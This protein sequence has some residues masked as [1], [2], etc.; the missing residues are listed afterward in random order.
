MTV[1]KKLLL[2]LFQYCV[3]WKDYSPEEDTWEPKESFE[4]GSEHFIE[5][6]WS[7]EIK[8]LNGRDPNQTFQFRHGEELVA[9][10][11]LVRKRGDEESSDEGNEGASEAAGPSNHRTR[12]QSPNL[13]S[14][15]SAR[16]RTTRRDQRPP[17]SD[18]EED[19][20]EEPLSR[21]NHHRPTTST[22]RNKHRSSAS[23]EEEVEALIRPRSPPPTSISAPVRSTSSSKKKRRKPGPGRDSQLIPED[24]EGEPVATAPIPS[25]HKTKTSKKPK[26]RKPSPESDDEPM[27]SISHSRKRRAA[28]DE[29]A[30]SK[31]PTA[32]RRKLKAPPRPPTDD[33]SS[34]D[35]QIVSAP[36]PRRTKPRKSSPE[37]EIVEQAPAPSP[38]PYQPPHHLFGTPTMLT[39]TNDWSY[40]QQGIS[41]PSGDWSFSLDP[42]PIE[43]ELTHNYPSQ[44]STPNFDSF[45]PRSQYT[46]A[47]TISSGTSTPSAPQ[48]QRPPASTNAGYSGQTN[49]GPSSEPNVGPSNQPHAGSAGHSQ[50]STSAAPPE[51]PIPFHRQRAANPR[52]RLMDDFASTQARGIAAKAKF[53]S[54]TMLTP[55]KP[56]SSTTPPIAS[57]APSISS[58][59]PPMP[60]KP[61]ATRPVSFATR[62]NMSATPPIATTP[63]PALMSPRPTGVTST[64]T[65]AT[66]VK[67]RAPL[68]KRQPKGALLV[69]D[70]EKQV[71]RPNRS[72]SAFGFGSPTLLE[73][74]PGM[75]EQ[76]QSP[77]MEQQQRPAMAQQQPQSAMEVERTNGVG[78]E[79]SSVT[80]GGEAVL[81]EQANAPKEEDGAT[82]GTDTAM[83]VKDDAADGGWQQ[84][85][86]NGELDAH[87]LFGESTADLFGDNET[88]LFGD[89]IPGLRPDSPPPSGEDLLRLAT[90]KPVA[91]ETLEDYEEPEQESPAV[92]PKPAESTAYGFPTAGPNVT[93]WRGSTIFGP[94]YNPVEP[95]STT[96]PN[97]TSEQSKFALKL[98]PDRWVPLV[99]VGSVPVP[100]APSLSFVVGNYNPGGLVPGKFYGTNVMHSL[101][102]SVRSTGPAARALCSPTASIDQRA[103]FEALKER[104]RAGELFIVTAGVQVLAFC[105]SRN[106]GA[107]ARLNLP[108]ALQGQPD[109][110]LM[111]RVVIENFA[112]YAEVAEKATTM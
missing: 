68:P 112:A 59:T 62:P 11:P 2:L 73:Q 10:G 51:K 31:R 66:L 75:G 81:D 14:S 71:L 90:G 111:S 43:P 78:N 87:D 23:D 61:T 8:G 96:P 108:P 29:K 38:Q 91:E 1:E 104:L 83:D 93:T 77:V 39:D 107:V 103:D 9:V 89:G 50:P 74:Q 65:G 19:S 18:D 84:G 88:D 57:A 28:D 21:S 99:L 37:P 17:P 16:T 13:P 85:D 79:S 58:T 100:D 63:N 35:I 47:L 20:D 5:E 76:R 105:H 33:G 6:F 7:R 55:A 15:S 49:A 36:I 22:S 97:D 69:Y 106:E 56:A 32:K 46:P 64:K 98:S 80:N 26:H 34:S 42:E 60:V 12:D 44:S 102:D 30:L 45:L 48:S 27:P 72:P 24:D 52:V 109:E 82:S 54:A 95:A 86:T 110:V 53:M 40:G 94:L 3:R 67:A 70:K 41:Q 101:L 4:G 92:V 25:K